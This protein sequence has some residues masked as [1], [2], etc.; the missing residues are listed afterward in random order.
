MGLGGNDTIKMQLTT[1]ADPRATHADGG[2]GKDTLWALLSDVFSTQTGSGDTISYH[3]R[4]DL[5][6]PHLNTGTFNGGTFKNFEIYQGIADWG[7]SAFD[8][9]GSSKGETAIG[10]L[11]RDSLNGRAGNDVLYGF[12]GADIL[13][14]GAGADH[15]QYKSLSDSTVDASGQDTIKDFKHSQGD[16]IDFS[17]MS[18][19][20]NFS[21]DYNFIGT[22]AFD[23][24]SSEVRFEHDNH[25]NTIV[26]VNDTNDKT[27]D[28]EIT[29]IG[30]INLVKGDFML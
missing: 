16:K 29:L 30:H 9:A 1:T 3:N 20:L 11:G 4:L 7:L 8:F 15:F 23:G 12:L 28:M 10:S 6:N 17:H 2:A 22:K 18:P 21:G 14:G 27:A 19:R 13:T 26:Q 24:K 25:G 5:E